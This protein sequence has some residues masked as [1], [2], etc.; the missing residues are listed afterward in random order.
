MKVKINTSDGEFITEVLEEGTD[1]YLV[2]SDQDWVW[3]RKD[4][5]K[6]ILEEES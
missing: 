3:I 5:C 4:Q 2:E 6:I 1:H